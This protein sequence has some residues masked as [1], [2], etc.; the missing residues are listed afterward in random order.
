MKPPYPKPSPVSTTS[1]R[2][3][4]TPIIEDEIQEVIP[5]KSEPKEFPPLKPAAISDQS[6]YN[7]LQQSNTLATAYD[8]TLDYTEDAQDGYEEY[9][10]QYMGDAHDFNTAAGNLGIASGK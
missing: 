4:K 3:D 2:F 1:S 8:E 6:T 5:I 10:D 9:H 7:H